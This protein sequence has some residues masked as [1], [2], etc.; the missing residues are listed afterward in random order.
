MYI[1]NLALSYLAIF[2]WLK[3]K[4][5]MLWQFKTCVSWFSTCGFIVGSFCKTLYA[6]FGIK[7]AQTE[8]NYAYDWLECILPF[9]DF[10][11]NCRNN[12]MYNLTWYLH[13][14]NACISY[15]LAMLL[16]FEVMNVFPYTTHV[17]PLYEYSTHCLIFQSGCSSNWLWCFIPFAPQVHGMHSKE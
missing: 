10:K 15:K 6:K 8:R 16:T 17:C 11:G 3:V 5:G 4:V 7:L 14:Q 9:R 13:M 12:W 1:H 2:V